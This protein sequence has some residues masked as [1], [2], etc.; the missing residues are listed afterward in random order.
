MKIN[1]NGRAIKLS[2][3]SKISY[4]SRWLCITEPNFCF[5]DSKQER[6]INPIISLPKDIQEY[7]SVENNQACV[8]VRTDKQNRKKLTIFPK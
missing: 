4:D 7:F 3:Q 6:I 1:I 2:S 5:E 8:S